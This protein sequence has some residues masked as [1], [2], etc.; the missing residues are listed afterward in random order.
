MGASF[1]IVN[2]CCLGE[3]DCEGWLLCLQW[4]RYHYSGEAAE[5]FGDHQDGYRF[6]WRNPGGKQL[7]RPARLPSL[8]VA[9]RLMAE[10]IHKEWGCMQAGDATDLIN[11]CEP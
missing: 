5:E 1:E 7:D 10:A 6:I 3:P 8:G 4:G 2:E 11:I 9:M